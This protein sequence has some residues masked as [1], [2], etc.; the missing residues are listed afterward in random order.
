MRP[1]QHVAVVNAPASSVRVTEYDCPG[2]SNVIHPISHR[3]DQREEEPE[4][5]RCPSARRGRETL[6]QHPHPKPPTMDL[7]PLIVSLEE[8]RISASRATRLRPRRCHRQCQPDTIATLRQ[9]LHLQTGT[10]PAGGQQPTLPCRLGV[11]NSNGPWLNHQQPECRQMTRLQGRLLLPRAR[12]RPLLPPIAIRTLI[13]L[14]CPRTTATR[15]RRSRTNQ[16]S[17]KRLEKASGIW[18]S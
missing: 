7:S 3:Q 14:G 17:R 16:N 6:G 5:R 4:E 15:Q 12:T 18:K 13:S 11:C 2:L 10:R 9:L 1:S 8:R